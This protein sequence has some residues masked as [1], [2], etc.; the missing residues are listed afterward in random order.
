MLQNVVIKYIADDADL[1]R[2]QKQF[3]QITQEEQKTQKA[4]QDVDKEAAKLSDSISG[5][6]REAKKLG[7]VDGPKK[8]ESS[9]NSSTSSVSGLSGM[10]KSVGPAILAAF[11]V[12]AVISF[13]KS[14]LDVTSKFQKLEA[15]LTNT[16]GS[17]SAA[18]KALADIKNFAA[19]TPFSVEQLTD[20]YVKLAN[21]GFTPTV[22]QLRKLGDLASSTGKGFDQLSEAILDAQTGEFERLKEFGIKASVSG[23]QVKFSFKGVKTEV[24]NTAASIQQYIL[25][26]GDLQGVSGSMSAISETLEGKISNLGDAFDSLLNTIGSAQGGIF[27]GFIDGLAEITK[28]IERVLKTSEQRDA[29][30]DQALI[31]RNFKDQL[32][33]TEVALDSYTKKVGSSTKDI[34][35]FYQAQLIEEERFAKSNGSSYAQA[36][37]NVAGQAK[38]LEDTQKRLNT[39]LTISQAEELLKQAKIEERRRGIYSDVSNLLVLE[40]KNRIKAIEKAEADGA[41]KSAKEE[42]KNAKERLKRAKELTRKLEEERKKGFA[43]SG[44]TASPVDDLDMLEAKKKRED[45]A[46]EEKRELDKRFFEENTNDADQFVKDDQARRSKQYE[47]EKARRKS[48]EDDERKHQ[49]EIAKIKSQAVQTIQGI[50]DAF[51]QSDSDQRNARLSSLQQNYNAELKLAGDNL[52]QQ[53]VVTN[54]YNI[55]Q[56]KI[57]RQQAQADK[58]QALFNIAINTAVGVSKAVPNPYLIALTL[59]LGAAQA[60][61]VSARPLPQYNKGTKFVKG[62]DVGNKDSVLAHLTVGE[63]VIPR[64]ANKKHKA[65][66]SG[67]IDGTLDP[68]VLD[69]VLNKHKVQHKISIV[70]EN[71]D[72]ISGIERGVE[73]A[74]SKQPK[75]NIAMDENGFSK[76]WEK[77]SSKTIILNNYLKV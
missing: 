47:E 13:G 57:K 49:A 37:L 42:E 27:S 41:E 65:L 34:I 32:K 77:K 52:Q 75:L 28:G 68:G 53:Q 26:L 40:I 35:A 48:D 20:S 67:I 44:G 22:E 14:V 30:I 70:N 66:I 16:L 15:I 50:G 9:V 74:L 51:F 1:I 25:S 7:D 21:Q 17:S 69:F 18:Q 46:R 63:A 59:A 31:N 55:E 45:R 43:A 3:Q 12:G 6:A 73:K 2:V 76:Y 36:I 24:D 23:D 71:K 29:E 61:V 5:A 56:L 4:L 8:L 60:A 10:V 39:G 64:E 19:V 62:Q 72:L 54:R 11:S 58:N 38:K 33:D